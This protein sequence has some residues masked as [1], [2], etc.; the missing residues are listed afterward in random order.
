M[1]D[2]AAL[3]GPTIHQRSTLNVKEKWLFPHPQL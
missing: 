3:V 1:S 2:A